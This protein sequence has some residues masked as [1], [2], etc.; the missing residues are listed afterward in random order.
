MSPGRG[1]NGKRRGGAPEHHPDERWMASYMDMVTVLMC[2]FIVLYAMSSVD[3]QKFSQLKDSL[4]TGFGQVNVGKV[5]TATGVIVTPKDVGK[6]GSFTNDKLAQALAEV[7]K[8]TALRDEMHSRL[9]K[10]G[11]ASN[12]EF[13]VDQRGLTV[14]LVGSQTFFLPDSPALS[15]RAERVLTAISPVLEKA[16]LEISIEGHAA[17]AITGYP[18]VWELSSERAVGVLRYLV[19]NSSIPGSTI[20]AV[21]YGASRQVNN[22]STEALRELNRRVDIVV[23]SSQKE[24][25][26]A[27]IPDALK[28]KANRP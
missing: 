12:V 20:G 5:D 22:D 24:D 2:L 28:V 11:L 7:D 6:E 25:V 26:R 15:V 14:K 18:S 8:L 1:R 19:E 27:L 17:N 10:A 4:A 9:A 21:G 3:S 23:L 13:A 16:K